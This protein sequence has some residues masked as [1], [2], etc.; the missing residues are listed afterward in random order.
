MTI[1]GVTANEQFE[2][3]IMSQTCGIVGIRIA[4]GYAEHALLKQLLQG[5][6]DLTWLPIIRQAGRE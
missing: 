3:R 2:H 1:D 6:L 4:T 5:V